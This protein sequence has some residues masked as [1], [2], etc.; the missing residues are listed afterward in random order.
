MFEV[1]KQKRIK[2]KGNLRDVLNEEAF[3]RIANKGRLYVMLVS[4]ITY[5]A[6]NVAITDNPEDIIAEDYQF[7]RM[8]QEKKARRLYNEIINAAN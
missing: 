5:R 7:V 2:D 6:F 1:I 4:N 3:N 8:V